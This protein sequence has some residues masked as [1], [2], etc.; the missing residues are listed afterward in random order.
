[1]PQLNIYDNGGRSAMFPCDRLPNRC[2]I[3]NIRMVP[4]EHTGVRVGTTLVNMFFQCSAMECRL[5]FICTY[6]R[7]EV[8]L[9]NFLWRLRRSEPQR[10]VKPSIPDTIRT[11]SPNFVEIY[12]QAMAAKNCNLPQLEGMGLRKAL[13]F[14]IKDFVLRKEDDSVR[15]SQ[16]QRKRLSA[17]IKE[18]ISNPQLKNAAKRANWLGNDET[19]YTRIWEMHD[20]EDLKKLILVSVSVIDG[21]L[22]TERYVN[23]MPEGQGKSNTKI[24][25]R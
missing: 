25:K 17:C 2:P 8:S 23:T 6:E 5:C 15:I 7:E 12:S 9:R 21:I 1:M 10:P 19:H 13:E 3:C 16:I 4:H 18:D 20:V 14:L 22:L 24:K 11:I